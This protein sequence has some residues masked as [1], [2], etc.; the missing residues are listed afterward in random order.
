MGEK[1]EAKAGEPL[2][3]CEVAGKIGSRMPIHLCQITRV[4]PYTL[5]LDRW[6]VP[7][8][9][10]NTRLNA[11]ITS[12]LVVTLLSEVFCPLV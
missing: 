3:F 10:L 9:G 11:L 1:T 7:A 4:M 2:A 8:T 6:A 5:I 12:F